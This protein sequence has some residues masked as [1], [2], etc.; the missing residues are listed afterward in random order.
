MIYII[1]PCSSTPSLTACWEDPAWQAAETLQVN[2]FLP[3]SSDHR[4]ETF[5][6]LL[7]DPSGLHGIYLVRDRYVHC[8]RTKYFDEVWKDSCVEFFVQRRPADGY[9]NFEFNC[10]GAYLANY[11][12]D[13]TL[14]E[15]GR[16]NSFKRLSPTLGKKV[17][18]KTSLPRIVEPEITDPIIWTLQFFIPFAVLETFFGPVGN[19]WGQIWRGNFFKCAQDVSHPHWAAWSPVSEFNFH[20][21]QCF[22]EL[23]FAG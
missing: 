23:I 1:R 18:V 3:Q 7:H 21:P 11:I 13:W 8:V 19:V 17:R 4:P 9:I 5:A 22:G 10:G 16:W 14:N 2:H 20:L 6:R 15:H 12:T